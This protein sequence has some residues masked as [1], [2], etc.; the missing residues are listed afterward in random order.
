MATATDPMIT[1][2]EAAGVGIDG[3]ARPT[4]D[5]I[6]VLDNAV[7]VLDGATALTPG[8]HTTTWYVDHLAEELAR[9]LRADPLADLRETLA[10]AITTLT[11]TH[12]LTPGKA[13]SSTVALL[14]WTD[15]AI[16]ALVLADSPIVAFTP[17]A[18][19]SWP[20]TASPPSPNAPAATAPAW[21]AAPV[22]PPTTR[23]RCAPRAQEPAACATSQVDSG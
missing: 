10:K 2:A 7:I 23:S 19:T 15:A 22:S 18:P 20:T 8:S 21:L 13:P 12:N 17:P 4:E 6:T 3:A 9:N 5:R 16:D 1:T 14:R 11:T